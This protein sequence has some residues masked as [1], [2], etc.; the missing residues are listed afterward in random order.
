MQKRYLNT[1]GDMV[2]YNFIK[3]NLPHHSNVHQETSK[4]QRAFLNQIAVVIIIRLHRHYYNCHHDFHFTNNIAC[5]SSLEAMI[6]TATE[7]AIIMATIF[8][9]SNNDNKICKYIYIYTYIYIH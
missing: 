1:A 5:Y 4:I 2:A 9:K 8:D 6:T 3:N 7:G